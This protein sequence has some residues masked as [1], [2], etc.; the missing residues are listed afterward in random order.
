MN[1]TLFRDG[2]F[3]VG[4]N[5]WASHAGTNMWRD[6]D[7]KTVDEDLARLAAHDVRVLRVFP[8]WSDFQPLKMLYGFRNEEIEIR[9]GEDLPPR[10]DAGRA[11][12][13]AVMAGRFGVLC[14]LAEKHGVRLVVALVTGWMSGRMYAPPL[15]D[16]VDVLRD[17]RA[18]KW[19]VRFVRYMVRTFKDKSAIAAWELGNECNCMGDAKDCDGAYLWANAIT[20]AI[21]AE[22]ASRPVVSGM[23]TTFPETPFRPQDLGEILDVLCTHPYP[24]FTQHC[25]TDPV[26]ETKAA[27][28]SVA[29]TVMYRGLSGKPAFVEE[30]GTLGPMIASEKNAAAYI[31]TVLP[32]LWAHNALGLLWWCGFEQTH[33][34]HAPY[35]WHATERELGLFH[36]DKTPKPVLEAIT[37][38]AK[39]VASFPYRK[40]PHRVVDAVCVLTAKQ[41]SWLAAYGS[42]ILA[43]QAGLDI[44]FCFAWDEI[45]QARAYLVPSLGHSSLPAHVLDELLSRT[46]NGAVLYL[47]VGN[48]VLLSPFCEYVGLEPQCHFI[49]NQPDTVELAGK[50]FRFLPK[51]KVPYAETTAKVLARDGGGT[52]V[53]SENA[54]GRGTVYFLTYPIEDVVGGT[55]GVVSGPGEVPY[56]EFYRAM[57]RLRS[58]EKVVKKDAPNVLYTEHVVDAGTRLVVAVNATP[59]ES[60]VTFAFDGFSLSRVLVGTDAPCDVS[61]GA[62]RFSMAPHG[63]VVFAIERRA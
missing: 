21:K 50:T 52:P 61:G 60:A 6:W 63:T 51:Y 32:L 44:E 24:L 11:G 15:F 19:E 17:P 4:C 57:P 13:S 12:V 1:D 2:E 26:T 14:D 18:I 5:Y 58:P 22:D 56:H 8:L 41:D 47:S 9:L 23:H 55:P 54:Y 38:F 46:E 16:G 20:A 45:P 3:F 42:F 39:T 7:E 34:T 30:I 35:D 53:M 10:T 43:K 25:M 59:R 29:E 33:L 27:L 36:A 49:P 48:D 28:H 40:L 37:A 31:G 62:A